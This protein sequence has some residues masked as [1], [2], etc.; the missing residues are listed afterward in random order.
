MLQSM[1]HLAQS[2]VVKGLMLLLM[3]SFCLW[4]I[5]DIFHGNPLRNN[6]ATVGKTEISVQQLNHAFEESLSQARRSVNPEMTA[7]QAKKLGLLD[8]TLDG[9]IKRSLVDQ[10]IKRLGIN[11]DQEAVLKLLA[12]QPQFRTKD[13]S[14]NKDLFRQL[15]A[16]QGL[17]E[18]SFLAQGQVDMARQVLLDG[19]GGSSAIPQTEIDN[20]YRARAQKRILDVISLDPTKISDIPAPNDAVLHDYY[21]KNPALFTAPEYRGMTIAVLS[22]DALTKDIAVSDDQVKQEYDGKKDQLATPEQRDIV[23]VVLQEESKAKQLVQQA[24]ASGDLTTA[25]R[26]NNESAVPLD[27]M[28][29]K[30]LLPE[31]A[32]PVFALSQGQISDPIKTQLGWHVVQVK[33]V[34][35]AGIPEFARIK[36]KLRTDMQRDQAVETATRQVNQLDD[37][38]AAG[39][40]LDDI[41]DGL[42][43]RLIKISGVDANGLTTEGKE[44]TELPDRAALLKD[45]FVQNSGESSAIEDDKAGNY[46]VVRTDAV[47]ASALLPFDQIKDKVATA[48]KSRQQLDKAQRDAEKIA[49]KLREGKSL[50]SFAHEEGVIV[51]TSTPLSQLGD[52]DPL[53]PPVLLTQAFQLKK[54]EVATAAGDRNQVVVRVATII[55]ADPTAQDPRKNMISGQIKQAQST[56]LVDEYLL[57][58]YDLFPV[59]IDAAL[60]D[61]LRQQ[62]N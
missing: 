14:F 24:R 34:E 6:V 52:S 55:D 22:T 50:D 19:L 54:G 26:Q 61:R 8:K 45:S 38:L 59:K 18:R 39:H 30:N 56:E 51:R 25:A 40:S 11:V 28:E 62:D 4:G 33:K 5:G 20:I 41:A 29:E 15:I 21:A 36:D 3:V 46:Y 60:M 2:W 10:D 31:L 48:W 57:H 32:K 58:L 43:M 35:S 44:P 17:T 9:E 47:T 13:G 53:L 37:E 49:Q 27:Q 1:R 42:K 12:D 23:Q 16:Q 7:A